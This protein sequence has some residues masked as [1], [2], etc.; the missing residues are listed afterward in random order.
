MEKLRGFLGCLSPVQQV[1]FAKRCG[2]T[3]GYIRKAMC[4]GEFLGAKTAVSIERETRGE[5]MRW[6]VRPV[7]WEKIW[8]ELKQHPNAP[9]VGAQT[10]EQAAIVALGL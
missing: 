1:E 3:I 5:V 7:D 9:V 6:D 8:P 2:T 4:V 10:N